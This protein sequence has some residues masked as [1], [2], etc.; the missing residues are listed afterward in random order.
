MRHALRA[1][2]RTPGTAAV[3]LLSLALGT[4]ANAAVYGVMRG[5][6]FA[7]PAGVQDPSHIVNIFTSE[8]SGATYGPSSYADYLSVASETSAFAAVAAIDDRAV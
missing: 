6:L 4:G 3:L 8:F 7:A 2:A 1:A 5:L